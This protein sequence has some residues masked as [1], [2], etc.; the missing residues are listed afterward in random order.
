MRDR[1]REISVRLPVTGCPAWR[2][3]LKRISGMLLLA[4]LLLVLAVGCRGGQSAVGREPTGVDVGPDESVSPD[5][6]PADDDFCEITVFNVG[7]A[8]SMLIRSEGHNILIDTGEFTS[9]S[10][11]IERLKKLGAEHLDLVI[12][13]HFDRDHVGGAPLILE[14]EAI[15]FDEVIYPDYSNNKSVYFSFRRFLEDYNIE[16]QVSS[17]K[18]YSFGGMTLSVYPVSDPQKIREKSDS[19]DND[20]SMICMLSYKEYKFLFMGDAEKERLKELLGKKKMKTALSCDWIKMPHHGEYNKR[21]PDLID[22]CMPKYAIIT[23][24]VNE[25]AEAA[26]MECLKERK[27]EI[28]ES[29]YGDIVTRVDENGI[30]ISYR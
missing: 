14:D 8:D 9:A 2:S 19:I 29:I 13:T 16:G 30:D 18:D 20:M 15:T 23:D 10:Y 24:S 5:I 27:V 4:G 17:Q 1:L 7:K 21:I 12:I 22:A 25:P 3:S 6:L 28:Y 26:V 11:I